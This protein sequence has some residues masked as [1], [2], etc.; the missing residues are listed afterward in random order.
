MHY[1]LRDILSLALKWLTRNI[2]VK[3]R[4]RLCASVVIGTYTHKQNR[5]HGFG[6][7]HSSALDAYWPKHGTHTHNK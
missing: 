6:F 2:V 1:T 5:T 3:C 4:P 7:L